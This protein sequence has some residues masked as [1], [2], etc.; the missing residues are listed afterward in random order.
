MSRVAISDHHFYHFNIIEY[1]GRPFTSVPEMNEAMIAA[2]NARVGPEDIVYHVGDFGFGDVSLLQ[3]VLKRLHGKEKHLIRGNHDP[4]RK[5]CLEIGWT[6]VVPNLLIQVGNH[7]VQLQHRPWE[8]DVPPPGV[9]VIVHGHIHN[10][11]TRRAHININVSCE[12]INY[13]PVD[14]DELVRNHM[15]VWGWERA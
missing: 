3:R 9:E 2:W 4:S 7:R 15:R 14:L 8:D 12:M 13:T 5:R 1:C 11:P 10:R 6:S